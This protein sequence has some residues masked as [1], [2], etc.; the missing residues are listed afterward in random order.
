MSP[1]W[2]KKKLTSSILHYIFWFDPTFCAV[3]ENWRV[4]GNRGKA[5]KLISNNFIMLKIK[6]HV[7]TN[8]NSFEKPF[9]DCAIICY[10]KQNTCAHHEPTHQPHQKHGQ[11]LI[12]NPTSSFSFTFNTAPKKQRPLRPTGRSTLLS[13]TVTGVDLRGDRW[14][15]ETTTG[16][17]ILIMGTLVL[18]ASVASLRQFAFTFLSFAEIL[19][20]FICVSMTCFIDPIPSL[21]SH[22]WLRPLLVCRGRI[23]E[24]RTMT[25]PQLVWNT[26]RMASFFML[27]IA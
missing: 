14:R 20:F 4:C 23:P 3:H 7:A 9:F 10:R 17:D 12:L 6:C 22:W 18:G 25:T 5:G 15:S 16:E 1:W 26:Q 8:T 19:A 13:H 24:K 2:G 11:T 27:S 21:L